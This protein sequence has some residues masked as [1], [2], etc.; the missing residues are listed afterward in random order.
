MKTNYILVCVA[1]LSLL[2][3]ACKKEEEE[4]LS[5]YQK[6]A[7]TWTLDNTNWLGAD[8]PGDG[9]TL[10]FYHCDNAPCEGVDYDASDPSAGTFTY[11]IINEDEQLA[12]V[13]TM[14]AGSNWNSTWDLLEFSETDLR[15]TTT[16]LGSNMIVEFTKQ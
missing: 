15:M 16:F 6:I 1:A 12:I 8:F 4:P 2:L 10:V 14:S 5:P 13:D 7:G 11:T 9:S 3:S